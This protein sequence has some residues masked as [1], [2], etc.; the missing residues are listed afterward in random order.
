[1]LKH[2]HLIV[3]AE[4]DNPPVRAEYVKKWL[5]VIIEGIGMKLA[6]GPEANPIAYRCNMEGNEGV[7]G[8]AILETSH[9][10]IHVW[11]GDRPY[12]VQFDLYSCS[13]FEVEEVLRYVNLFCPTKV[14]YRFFDRENG[15]TEIPVCPS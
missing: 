4:V 2:K 9:C 11:D 3:R 1:M 8:A 15:L 6:K 12:I 13:D 14:E 10:V 7:T 5:E